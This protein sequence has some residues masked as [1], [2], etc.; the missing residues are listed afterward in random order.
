MGAFLAIDLKSFYASVECAQ[1]GLDALDAN[2]VVADTSRT[3]KTICLAV[4]PSLKAVGVGGRARLFEAIEKVREVNAARRLKAPNH[5]F[6]GKSFLKSELDR[7][8]SLELTFLTARPRMSLYMEYSGK[9]FTIYAKYIS[10]DDIHVYS[11]DEV[12]IDAQPYLKIYGLTPRQLCEKLIHEVYDST[13]V[14][15]TAGIGTNMYLA[16]VAMDIVAKH[17]QSD[18]KGVRIAE[19]DEMEYRRQL[20]SHTPLTDFWRVG[21]GTQKKLAAM[22]IRTMGDIARCSLGGADMRANEEAL[23][24]LFGVNAELLI[25]HAWGYESC[26]IRDIKAYRAK[27]SSLSN[28]QVL[29]EPY[30][31]AAARVVIREMAGKLALELSS[32]GLKAC[33]LSAGVNYDTENL[34]DPERMKTVSNQIERDFYGRPVPKGA[35]GARR[36]NKPTALGEDFDRAVCEI[37]DETT[38]PSLLVRRLYVAAGEVLDERDPALVIPEQLDMFGTDAI[39]ASEE[40]SDARKLSRQKAIN[41]IQRRFGKN[42]IFKGLSLEKG[43]TALERN[44]QIGGHRA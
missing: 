11:V 33:T 20:W 23:Y 9:V 28:G 21:R 24:K 36:F 15:A 12:F 35:G 30:E 1:R 19:L 17:M 32:R 43:A 34:N 5:T 42:A 6:T 4:S 2:L 16:K 8:P 13:G 41:E 22:G 10:P 14:T 27:A 26:E 44:K 31:N 7:D 38:N 25:D 39:S 3:E 37:F 40:A 29:A 18:S